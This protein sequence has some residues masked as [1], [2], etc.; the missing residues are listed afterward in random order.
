MLLEWWT[1]LGT[2]KF[3][4]IIVGFGMASLLVALMT[5]IWDGSWKA[6][7]SKKQKLGYIAFFTL[8]LMAIGYW[9]LAAKGKL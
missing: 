4:V 5:G 7:K 6:A 1:S 2:A 9:V 3:Q 8:H